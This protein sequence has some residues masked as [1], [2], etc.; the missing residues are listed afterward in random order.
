V[1]WASVLPPN[2]R[3]G[4]GTLSEGEDSVQLTPTSLDQLIFT[5]KILFT[6]F[7]K[8]ATLMRRSTVMNLPLWLVFPD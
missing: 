7:T 6:F 8:Q 1:E 3:L 4:Q 2:I 5:L